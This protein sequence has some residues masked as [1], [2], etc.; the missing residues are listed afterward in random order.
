MTQTQQRQSTAATPIALADSLVRKY[1]L[2]FLDILQEEI[3]SRIP[4]GD[5]DTIMSEEQ[6]ALMLAEGKWAA[7]RRFASELSE[8]CSCDERPGS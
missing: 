5:D 8:E 4:E 2:R 3:V 7:L 6:R 1:Q